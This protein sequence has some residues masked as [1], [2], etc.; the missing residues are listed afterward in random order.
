[1]ISDFN[2]EKI[3]GKTIK[4]IFLDEQYLTFE[5]EDGD[6]ITYSVDGDCCSHSVWYDFFGVESLIGKKVTGVKDVELTQDDWLLRRLAGYDKKNYQESISI[7]G[8]QID[9][10]GVRWGDQTAVVSFR[11]YSNG[12]YGGSYGLEPDTQKRSNNQIFKDVL[13][14]TNLE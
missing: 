5:T 4:A 14:T 3:I 12:Y 6:V 10:E 13:S 7:Y 1:M 8:I 11:N 2:M 9:F